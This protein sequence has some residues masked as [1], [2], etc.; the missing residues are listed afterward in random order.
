MLSVIIRDTFNEMLLVF[1][2]YE[3]ERT[4]NHGVGGRKSL[5]SKEKVLLM[6]SY[7]REYRT[8]EHI[9]LLAKLLYTSES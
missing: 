3:K 8:L 7:Y 2:A 6:L 4:K 9:R 1:I 5:D